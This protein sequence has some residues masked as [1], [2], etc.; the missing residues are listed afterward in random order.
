MQ[1]VMEI[2]DATGRI[3]KSQKVQLT[4][5]ENLFQMDLSHLNTGTYVI[6]LKDYKN[7]YKPI[8]FVKF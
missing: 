3:V 6:R 2:Y 8:R 5:G 1:D 7:I 4:V